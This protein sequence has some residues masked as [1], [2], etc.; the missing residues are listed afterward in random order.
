MVFTRGSV[1]DIFPFPSVYSMTHNSSCMRRRN[2]I[3]VQLDSKFHALFNYA[4][5]NEEL[6][7][8]FS[9]MKDAECGI[10]ARCRVAPTVQHRSPVIG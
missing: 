2:T 1:V 5:Q 10:S 7:I 9:V 4:I 8:F 6:S 3:V